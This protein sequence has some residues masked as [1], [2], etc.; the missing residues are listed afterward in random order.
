MSAVRNALCALAIVVLVAVPLAGCAGGESGPISA[1]AGVGFV[2]GLIDGLKREDDEA[3]LKELAE[4]EPSKEE[5]E[6]AH[7]RAE[8]V[9]VAEALAQEQPQP[10]SS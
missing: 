6:A 7:E 1:Q 3:E 8:D 9:P 4:H 2:T 5:R 10:E